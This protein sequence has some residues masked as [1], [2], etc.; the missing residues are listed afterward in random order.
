MLEPGEVM[1]LIL[2]CQNT[3][4]L[5][6]C[7]P[8]L[9]NRSTKTSTGTPLS[10]RTCRS[11]PQIVTLL[12]FCLKTPISSSRLHIMNMSMV[13]TWVPPLAP[14]SPTCLWKSSKLSP[15]VL[16]PPPNLWYRYVDNSFVNQQAKH[17]HQLLQYIN[18]QDP[19]SQF[20]MENP[21]EDGA[22]PFLDTLVSPGPNN[23][24]TTIV[25]RKPPDMDQYLHWDSNHFI[26]AKNSI[27]N[28]LTYRA[29]VVC[30]N[31]LI[32]QQENEHIRKALVSCKFPSLCSLTDYKSNLTTGTT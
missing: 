19:H 28:T 25:C 27:F 11:I 6:T 13:Q 26:S 20:T 5:S 29:R 9:C 8:L 31:Q 22:L 21:N 15:A 7:G 1:A 10:H 16:L 4:H 2:Q 24:L 32:L 12:E 30:S 3:L 17:S 18:S 23:T 14:L